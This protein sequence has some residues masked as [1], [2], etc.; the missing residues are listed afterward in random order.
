MRITAVESGTFRFDTDTL[1]FTEICVY[2]IHLFLGT[3]YGF[4][5]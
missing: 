2:L 4:F 3:E 5:R 1:T